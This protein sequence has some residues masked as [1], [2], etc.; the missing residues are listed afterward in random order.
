MDISNRDI[1]IIVLAEIPIAEIFKLIISVPT[2]LVIT[3]GKSF[4]PVG[5]E[6]FTM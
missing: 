3:Q 6:V 1:E 5:N 4:L 2:M